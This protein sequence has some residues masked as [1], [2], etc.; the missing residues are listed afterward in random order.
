LADRPVQADLADGVD[1]VALMMQ[2][3]E[4]SRLISELKQQV[5]TAEKSL[6]DLAY[7]QYAKLDVEAIKSLLVD[8]KWMG[9]LEQSLQAETDRIS[10]TLTRRV[11][12]LAER[13]DSPLPDLSEQVQ[14]LEAKVLGHLKRMGVK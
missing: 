4:L 12:D 8:D 14:T 3:L 7:Q 10:Q 2:W 1:E 9:H 5:K 6:D 13:Y 11:K